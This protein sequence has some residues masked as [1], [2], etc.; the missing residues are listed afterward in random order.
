L[1]CEIADFSLNY[2]L[3]FQ[4]KEECGGGGGDYAVVMKF[5]LRQITFCRSEALSAAAGARISCDDGDLIVASVAFPPT[6]AFM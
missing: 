5:M 6:S 1:L 2:S 3:R 4:A